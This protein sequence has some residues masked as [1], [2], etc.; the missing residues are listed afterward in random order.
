MAGRERQPDKYAVEGCLIY[1]YKNILYSNGKS[2]L[3][4]NSLHAKSLENSY[5]L[6]DCVPA[7]LA[8]RSAVHERQQNVR[9]ALSENQIITLR[10]Q[11]YSYAYVS[12][13]GAFSTTGHTP[14]PYWTRFWSCVFVEA[15]SNVSG[16]LI[17]RT[18]FYVYLS[19]VL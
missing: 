7:V 10:S 1:Q 6:V 15:H 9:K 13:Q 17:V 5:Q 8:I 16:Q 12:D 18:F 11:Q 19:V 2:S 3:T 4:H 14:N